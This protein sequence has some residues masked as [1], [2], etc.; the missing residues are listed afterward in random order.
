[1]LPLIEGTIVTTRFGDINTAHILFVCAG[2]FSYA[3]PTDLMP[4]LLGRLP[5]RI[6]LKALNRHDF[7][8]VLTE[9]EFNLLMQQQKL[10]QTENIEIEWTD[11]GIDYLCL[12]AEE[13]NLATE[14]IGTR[15]LHSV[16]EKVVEDISFEGPDNE[17]KYFL[18]DE[19][20]IKRKLDES[21]KAVDYS[22]YML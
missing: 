3:S 10:L 5:N 16:I 15:R 11:D 9:V 6:T 4:E 13:M 22:R 7:K 8:R 21:R 14:N 1:L 17:N 20:F 2:A 12:A 19:A 18:I